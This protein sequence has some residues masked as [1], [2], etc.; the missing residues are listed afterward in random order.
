MLSLDALA[1]LVVIFFVQLKA[2]EVAVLLVCGYAG[3]SA[4]AGVVQYRVPFVGIGQDKV[5][6]EVKGLLGGVEGC[7]LYPPQ[8]S[9]RHGLLWLS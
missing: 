1:S 9:E 8:S 5:T 2:D 6:Q 3:G 4:A 7:A